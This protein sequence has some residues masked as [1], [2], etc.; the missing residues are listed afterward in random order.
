MKHISNKKKASIMIILLLC[1]TAAV[2][3]AIYKIQVLPGGTALSGTISLNSESDVFDV[4]INPRAEQIGYAGK[5]HITILSSGGETI[6]ELSHGEPTY[7]RIAFDMGAERWWGYN[8]ID[9]S[10]H[11]FSNDYEFVES[12]QLSIPDLEVIDLFKVYNSNYML[13]AGVNSQHNG[14]IWIYDILNKDYSYYEPNGIALSLNFVDEDTLASLISSSTGVHI[15]LYN[16]S[17]Q[18]VEGTID[19]NTNFAITLGIDPDGKIYYASNRGIYQA[20]EDDHKLVG[21]IDNIP[22]SAYSEAMMKIFPLSDKCY[23]WVSGNEYVE[24]VEY[25]QG[26]KKNSALVV[27]SSF[28]VPAAMS[29]YEESGNRVELRDQGIVSS[30]QYLT[31]MLSEDASVDVYRLKSYFGTEASSIIEKG[32]YVDLMQSPIIAEDASTWFESIRE[33][34]SH[35]GEMFGYPYGVSFQMLE[36]QPD[37]LKEYGIELT[38]QEITWNELLDLLEPFRGQKP[39]PLIVNPT[40]LTQLLLWQAYNAGEQNVE[41]ALEEAL[42]IITRCKDLGMYDL[43]PAEYAQTYQFS[44]EFGMRIELNTLGGDIERPFIAVPSLE[45]S[46]CGTPVWYDWL[47]INPYSGQKDKAM[48]FLEAHAIAHKNGGLEWTA[49]LAPIP[50]QYPRLS[51]EW[52]AQY[53]QLIS[54]SA[55]YIAYPLEYG[56]VRICEQYLEGQFTMEDALGEMVQKYHLAENE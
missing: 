12:I 47:L 22:E 10:F 13:L 16:V 28:Y 40:D 20:N 9:N 19:V 8:S 6:A 39:F 33:D 49:V 52:L 11:A 21:Y 3:A 24:C 17:A 38:N 2:V 15:E 27:D 18:A 53:E 34:S 54:H 4:A 56:Y 1:V 50:E 35:N 41:A 42:Q 7:E 23:V 26:E 51:E 14:T 32:F 43:S 44:D 55:A 25:A 45:N 48:E 31:M 29:L 36:Y 5:E 30:E 46:Q 37:T